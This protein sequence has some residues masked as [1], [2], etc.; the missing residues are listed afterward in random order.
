MIL[1]SYQKKTK[2]EL[3]QDIQ[4]LQHQYNTLG[5]FYN[6]DYI[7]LVEH[8]PIAIA[9]LNTHGDIEF[10]NQKA[11]DEF[12]YKLEDIKT[13]EN[14][15]LN[16]YPDEKYRNEVKA[17][18][19]A[20]MTDALKNGSQIE[21]REYWITC[22]DGRV[23]TVYS[24]GV[25]VS[26]RVFILFDDITDRKQMQEALREREQQYR[27][28]SELT[29]DY[30]Y[31][32]Y[33]EK[34]GKVTM[35]FVSDNFFT[36]T[37]R[38]KKEAGPDFW[39]DIIHPDDLP[40]L[41]EQLKMLMDKPQSSEIECR[42]Y[43]HGHKLRWVNVVS[44][45]EWDEKE[46]RVSTIRGAVKDITE[47]KHAEIQIHEKNE[48][49]EAKNKEYIRLNEELIKI[50]KQ[51][52]KAKEQAEESDRLKTSFLQ[53]MSHEIR[54]P[55]NAIM[56]FSSLLADNYN[57][58]AK[59]EKFTEIIN[60][61]CI[62]LLE[63][64]NDLLDISK[65]ES[66]QLHLH[67]EECN[68]IDLFTELNLF[69]KEHQKRAGK[70]HIRFNLQFLCGLHQSTIIVDQ[71]KLKQILIN[72]IGNAFKFTEEGS[73]E[74]GCKFDE[75]HNMIFFVSDTGIGIPHDKH[76]MIF[77]RFSQVTDDKIKNYGGTGLG[78]S[79]VKG[80]INLMGGTVWLESVTEDKHTKTRGGTTFYF[81]FPGKDVSITS[82]N[83]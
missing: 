58:K 50:N 56:G 3:I 28:I 76:E 57:N 53:N 1:D 19:M 20:Y 70:D 47:R 31:S 42:S 60:S 61:R 22:K 44:R 40:K 17:L 12:G 7:A 79:I 23:K 77:E 78:L 38:D 4:E 16:A 51:L 13:V 71:V 46:Q 63:I 27:M 36:I 83:H 74:G 65:I 9:I 80:L 49:I 64:I 26:E 66:G 35:N 24:S 14:W 67:N 52:I 54:T 81:S 75:N 43:I 48:A 18:W 41:M 30:I 8:A 37:G 11:F 33:I 55:M 68:L 21:G 15:W 29:T 39:G 73:I 82:V 32:L 45:S 34:S 59:L 5:T 25:I 2:K 69:F 62:D 10:I 72:L 6:N